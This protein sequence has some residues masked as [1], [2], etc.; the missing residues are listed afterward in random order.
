MWLSTFFF[1]ADASC[2]PDDSLPGPVSTD[3][4]SAPR[5]H[6]TLIKNIKSGM[7][8]FSFYLKP[9]LASSTTAINKHIALCNRTRQA[10]S[11]PAGG[12]LGLTTILPVKGV[13]LLNDSFSWCFQIRYDRTKKQGQRTESSRQVHGKFMF[14]NQGELFAVWMPRIS[15]LTVSI[16]W[17]CE[18]DAQICLFLYNSSIL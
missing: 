5:Y 7:I 13:D 1:F 11:G 14:L 8:L 2:P 10:S 17:N 18:C 4:I 12:K 16:L 9:R 6:P 15:L 3:A